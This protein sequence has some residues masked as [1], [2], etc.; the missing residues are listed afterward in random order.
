MRLLKLI[1]LYLILAYIGIGAILN[2]AKQYKLLTMAKIKNAQVKDQISKLSE[3]NQIL[4]QKIEYAT[5]SAYLES[6]VREK[7]GL[8]RA[9]D[10]WIKIGTSESFTR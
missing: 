7:L 9:N 2:V 6:Q 1:G 8:G 10:V 4:K 5:T 3:E